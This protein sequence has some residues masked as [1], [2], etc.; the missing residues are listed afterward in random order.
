M[1]DSQTGSSGH[2]AFRQTALRKAAVQWTSLASGLQKIW[3]S[4]VARGWEAAKQKKRD[5]QKLKKEIKNQTEILNKV[6]KQE[7]SI[8]KKHRILDGQ[9]KIKERELKIY[10]W[11]LKINRNNPTMARIAHLDHTPHNHSSYLIIHHI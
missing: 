5:E 10:N 7:Y 6:G 2:H 11:N 4:S 9:L 1:N 8:L 3:V